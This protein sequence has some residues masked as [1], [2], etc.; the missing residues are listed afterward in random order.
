M[1][2]VPAVAELSGL[3]FAA[4]GRLLGHGGEEA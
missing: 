2:S 1:R 4:D 3:A